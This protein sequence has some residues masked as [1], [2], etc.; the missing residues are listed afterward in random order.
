MLTPIIKQGD[1][2]IYILLEIGIINWISVR[3]V[4]IL[5]FVWMLIGS[6]IMSLNYAASGKGPLCS[7]ASQFAAGYAAAQLSSDKR[8]S[9]TASDDALS[10]LRAHYK[11]QINLLF[12]LTHVDTKERDFTLTPKNGI[13]R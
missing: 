13:L 2:H 3:Y 5:R 9:C 8:L 4:D 1:E 11:M 7:G 10:I 12:T 6:E